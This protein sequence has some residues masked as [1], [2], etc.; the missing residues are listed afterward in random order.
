MFG[1]GKSSIVEDDWTFLNECIVPPSEQNR[2]AVP[3]RLAE[4]FRSPLY[5]TRL[6]PITS[7]VSLD[8]ENKLM[9]VEVPPC[10][11]GTPEGMALVQ[12]LLE[13]D[14]NFHLKEILDDAWSRPTPPGTVKR[15]ERRMCLVKQPLRQCVICGISTRSKCNACQDVYYC[16]VAC[17]KKHWSQHRLQCKA[18]PSAVEEHA[19]IA[20]PDYACFWQYQHAMTQKANTFS[21]V[22]IMVM[23]REGF[24]GMFGDKAG[25]KTIR[26]LA[27]TGK[28][29]VFMAKTYAAW[30]NSFFI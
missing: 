13:D 28:P 3:G 7:A 30:E 9:K 25:D 19:C 8:E 1:S 12:R 4:R 16:S 17:Q 2:L 22:P 18:L 21:H 11:M 14:W 5:Y 26:A 29:E 24:A 10:L 15:I 20:V 23:S 6:S 27:V